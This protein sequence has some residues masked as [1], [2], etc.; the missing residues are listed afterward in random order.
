VSVRALS[1]G[2]PARAG[3]NDIELAEISQQVSRTFCNR[4]VGMRSV[5]G[6]SV[7]DQLAVLMRPIAVAWTEQRK[8]LIGCLPRSLSF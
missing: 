2:L 8:T 3:L 7:G 4:S 1:S 5:V 6:I